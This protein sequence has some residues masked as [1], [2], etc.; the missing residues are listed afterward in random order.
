[1][2]IFNLHYS[3]WAR[4]II[5]IGAIWRISAY[6]VINPSLWLDEAKFAI[7]TDEFSFSQLWN[8]DAHPTASEE[9][10]AQTGP[11]GFFFLTKVLTLYFGNHEYVLRFIPLLTGILGIYFFYLLA[12]KILSP[13][14]A[15]LALAFFSFS[16]ILINFSFDFHPYSSDVFIAVI[17]SHL[18]LTLDQRDMKMKEALLRGMILAILLWFSSPAIFVFLGISTVL[19]YHYFSKKEWSKLKILSI[20]IIFNLTSFSINYFSY[21]T[22]FISSQPITTYWKQFL[23]PNLPFSISSFKFL[24]NFLFTQFFFYAPL[25]FIKYS[26]LAFLLFAFGG[27]LLFFQKRLKFFLLIGPLLITILASIFQKY[28]FIGR[29]IVFLTPIAYILIAAGIEKTISVLRNLQPGRWTWI[30]IFLILSIYIQQG[31]TTLILT[32]SKST[33][34]DLAPVLVEVR[35][36]AQKTDLLYIYCGAQAQFEY[37]HQR[38][39]LQGLPT[40]YGIDSREDPQRYL[41]D[42]NRLRGR[43]RVW[44]IFSHI[45]EDEDIVYLDHL[46]HIGKMLISI[47]SWNAGAFLYDLSDPKE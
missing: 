34:E 41:Q 5:L 18:F 2:K 43:G 29:T 36:R 17:F 26:L 12:Q 40:V 39:E 24:C 1:M 44:F 47:P 31:I 19:F 10:K 45:W 27:Y 15:L 7:K 33:N 35:K 14:G 16:P 6:L 11:L 23:I 42:I 37:Y 25:F 8:P 28:P 32:T 13:R 9:I 38:F 21:L 30:L 20:M 3:Q 46:D 4:I 22:Y